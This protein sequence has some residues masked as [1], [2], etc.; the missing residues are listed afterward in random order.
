MHSGS[1]FVT[2]P[3]QQHRKGAFARAEIADGQPV[4]A[5]V[6]LINGRVHLS[7]R[8]FRQTTLCHERQYGP[9]LRPAQASAGVA[10][11]REAALAG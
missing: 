1:E 10:C 2:G 3:V 7:W 11:K 6:L 9:S 5:E 4:E 8:P